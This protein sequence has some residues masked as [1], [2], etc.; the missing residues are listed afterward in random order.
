VAEHREHHRVDLVGLA[1]QGSEPL[2]LLRVGDLD[3]PALLLERVMDDPGPGHRLDHGAD[4]L[5]VRLL[6][7]ARERS[8]RASV[9]RNDR[10][11]ELF[12]LI[13]E[14]ADIDFLSTQVE[15]SVQHVKRASLVCLG[16]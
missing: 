11:V 2:D 16:R 15:S 1:G 5:G 9:G 10:L 8:Q 6:D 12:A 7:S 13:A 4:G 3:R 14:K